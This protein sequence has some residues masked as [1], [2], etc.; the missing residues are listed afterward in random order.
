MQLNL[1]N[2]VLQFVSLLLIGGWSI[3]PL[4]AQQA[5]RTEDPLSLKQMREAVTA[6]QQGNEQEAI[7][8]LSTLL[9][10]RPTFEPALKL[11][12]MLFE[13]T[14]HAAEAWHDYEEALKGAPSD[15]ELLQKVG[16]SRLLQGQYP[17][18][19]TLFVHALHIKPQQPDALYYLAQAYHL[20]GNND[21]ALKTIR[22]AVSVSPASPPVW[23]K[24]GELLCSSGNN[25][26][27]LK[28]LTKAQQ[29]D[30]SL[31]RINFD[32]AIA[33]FD[34][35]NLDNAVAFATKEAQLVPSNATNLTL[36]AAAELK[37]SR[38]QDAKANLEQVV[39]LRS[40][41][42]AS[43]LELGHCELELK[44][45]QAAIDT[46]EHSLQLDPTQV[47]G[48]FFLSRAYSGLGNTA[49]AQHQ[50]AL[51]QDM[52]QHVAFTMAKSESL[53]ERSLSEKARKLLT[54]GREPD[55]LRLFA[56]NISGPSATK[57]SPWVSVGAIYLSMADSANAQR[58]LKKALE[59]DPQTRGAHTYLGIMALQQNNLATA[60]LH[61]LAE[62][63]IDPNHPVAGA[64]LGEVRYRQRRWAEASA[65]IAKSKTTMPSLMFML[66]DSY[67]HLGQI[68]E[69]NLTAE[70]LA[71][72]GR[73]EPEVMQGLHDL[74]LRN[75][76]NDLART[77]DTQHP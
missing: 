62:L 23:Q 38:W 10:R 44:D 1:T 15:P 60:E 31:D 55:A 72:F 68:K 11:Q 48:H 7:S 12:G 8:I 49:E 46:I 19:I 2:R 42:A 20:K 61:F 32:L 28:W 33:S 53:R 35:M 9:T 3:V 54:A 71:A 41:D 13:D 6:A 18:A 51:H 50:S 52:M 22:E 65:L 24:Y 43:L 29:A 36:L 67:F 27:A 66:C 16:V 5:P 59:I 58:A 37:L 64:E 57:G 63:A 70:S 77:I 74:L 40:D 69:A 25:E 17:E 4:R 39:A 73:G 45:Y 21:L 56:Q 14:G 76:Q 47:Q 26:E 75:G 30:P 34:N